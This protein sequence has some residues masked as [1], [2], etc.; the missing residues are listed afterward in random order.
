MK[1]ND[2]VCR[3]LPLKSVHDRPEPE[4][5]AQFAQYVPQVIAMRARALWTSSPVKLPESFAQVLSNTT[6]FMWYAGLLA[7]GYEAGRTAEGILDDLKITDENSLRGDVHENLGLITSFYGVS[8]RGEA[9]SRMIKA[10]QSWRTHHAAIPV[11]RITREDEV[12]LYIAESDL[13]FQMLQIDNY[14][15]AERHIE[16]CLVQYRRWGTEND[17]PF[18]YLKYYCITSYIRMSQNRVVEAIE[19]ASRAAKLAEKCAGIEHPQTQ[20]SRFCL[21]NLLYFAGEV[22]KALEINQSILQIRSKV[23][24]EFNPFTLDSHAVTGFLLMRTDRL[25]DAE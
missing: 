10:L 7:Q 11:D 22:E 23:C 16:K 17:V 6:W 5:W 19:C 15:K 13:A 18:E 2:L 8:R 4:T 3:V 25:E 9:I 24:G 12:R 21:A 14:K 20:L 1:A